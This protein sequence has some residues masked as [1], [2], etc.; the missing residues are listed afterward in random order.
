MFSVPHYGVAHKTN[1]A[2]ETNEAYLSFGE[3]KLSIQT[4]ARNQVSRYTRRERN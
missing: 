3:S 1:R 4:C 2:E